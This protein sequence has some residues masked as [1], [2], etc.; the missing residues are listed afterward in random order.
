MVIAGSCHLSYQVKE[1]D[2]RHGLPFVFRGNLR[3]DSLV[4]GG[5]TCGGCGLPGS[6]N[7][8]GAE[9][10]KFRGEALFGVHLQIQKGA[11][12]RGASAQS[13]KDNEQAAIVRGKKTALDTP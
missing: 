9:G 10:T 11:G 3:K 6:D 4:E 7:H 13:Q 2:G 12:D 5:W 1:P 8:I